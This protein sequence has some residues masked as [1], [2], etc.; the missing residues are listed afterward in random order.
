MTD[1][2]AQRDA[3]TTGVG[4]LVV[5]AR[6][7]RHLD[8]ASKLLGLGFVA[9]GLDVGGSTPTGLALAAIGTAL[10]LT[11]VFVRRQT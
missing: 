2:D 3:D 9:L 5:P 11:T 6:T 1:A 8:R 7:Y 4:G 10:A